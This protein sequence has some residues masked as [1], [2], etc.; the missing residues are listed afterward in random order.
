R[1]GRIQV[2]SDL[3]IAGQPEIF[4]VGDL[5]SISS[6]GK[7]VPGVCPAAKQMG[8]TAA[9]NLLRRMKGQKTKAFH[10]VDY[11]SLATIGRKA[12][13][14]AMGKIKFSG[15]VAWLFWL[16]VHIF[17]LIGFRNRLMVMT[18]WAWAYITFQRNARIVVG[19]DEK[20]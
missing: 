13:V 3:S 20:K 6:N 9:Q 17:F 12:A 8:R 4:V 11:G 10:Y 16:F 1:S 18:D 14:V 2:E 5:A 19:T 15:F 7:P